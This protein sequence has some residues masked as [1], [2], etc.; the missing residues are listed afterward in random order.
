MIVHVVLLKPRPD[1]EESERRAFADA[2][3]GAIREIP[4][5]RGVRVGRRVIHGAGYEHEAPDAADFVGMLEFDDLSGL[6]D[7]L[8]HP[9]HVQLGRLFT[10]LLAS[11]L[12]YDF[13]ITTI[14]DLQRSGPPGV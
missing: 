6:R 3:R 4:A 2:F 7:Y 11:A 1:L 13:E 12:V 14:E 8:A 9:A 10:E 5:I